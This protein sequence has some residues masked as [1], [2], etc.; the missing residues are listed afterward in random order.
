MVEYNEFLWQGE[1]YSTQVEK[2]MKLMT[3]KIFVFYLVHASS[4]LEKDFEYWCEMLWNLEVNILG[5]ERFNNI[6]TKVWY[7]YLF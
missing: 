1:S 2:E 5:F 6:E 3:W 7:I 4:F